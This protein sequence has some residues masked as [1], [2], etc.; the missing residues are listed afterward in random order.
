M[1]VRLPPG[2]AGTGRVELG[3]AFARTFTVEAIEP[4]PSSS[5]AARVPQHAL[6]EV[7]SGVSITPR[8]A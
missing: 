4:Q 5:R 1:T 3:E 8:K 6:L 7:D 2:A